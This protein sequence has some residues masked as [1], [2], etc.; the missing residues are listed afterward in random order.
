[1]DVVETANSFDA[2]LYHSRCG[3]KKLMFGVPKEQTYSGK[4]TSKEEFLIMVRNNLLLNNY[5]GNY[6]E[7][8]MK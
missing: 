4:R 8:Y 1:M 2:W 6:L 3:S 5:M 7:E